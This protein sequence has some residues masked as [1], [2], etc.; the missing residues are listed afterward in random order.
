MNVIPPV[1]PDRRRQVLRL[2]AM[3]AVLALV[4]WYQW[5]P[6]EPA[7]QASNLPAAAPPVEALRLPE[8]VRLTDLDGAP[9]AL[10]V[11][12]N[13]FGFGWG[14]PPPM[15]AGAEMPQAAPAM[16][17]SPAV[18]SG[19][20][21]IALRLTGMMVPPGMARTMVTLKDP[22][23]GALFH[24]FEGD[25]VDGRYRIVKIGLQSVVVSYVDGSGLRTLGLGN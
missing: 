15:P 6:T 9:G 16:P 3:L 20:P 7:P 17:S 21:P 12:R 24:A 5:R 8:P 10:D 22:G 1:G 25:V 18:P 23:S 11:G 14:P 19:P 4:V 13:P 2:A